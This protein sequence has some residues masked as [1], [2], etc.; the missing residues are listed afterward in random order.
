[1]ETDKMLF[2]ESFD[3]YM[4]PKAESSQKLS[5]QEVLTLCRVAQEVDSEKAGHMTMATELIHGK[6]ERQMFLAFTFCLLK[7][8]K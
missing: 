2:V 5:L 4:S 7:S 8:Q 3:I 6:A 1:M